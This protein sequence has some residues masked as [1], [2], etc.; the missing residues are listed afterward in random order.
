M[1]FEELN[2]HPKILKAIAQAGYSKP[3]PI[4][5]D[6][7]PMIMS[8]RDLRAS[9][10][11]GTGKTA[12]FML[13]TLNRLI[14]PSALPGRGPRVLVLVPTREL[15]MQV[16]TE[17]VKYSKF[18]SR[19]KTVCLFGGVPYPM[20]IRELARPYEILVATP[21][22]LL[23]HCEQIRDRYKTR[24]VVFKCFLKYSVHVVDRYP[25]ECD[26]TRA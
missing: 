4:Q 1:S 22:R 9:A 14:E 2:L 13:P 21:G 26:P 6:A 7:I 17:A 20:Q 25:R 12:A 18:L 11:T 24:C 10:Q 19:M 5:Q 16:A 15:A 3:T 8:G 23:D